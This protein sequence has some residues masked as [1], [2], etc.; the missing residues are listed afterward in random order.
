VQGQGYEPLGSRRR[1]VYVVF[2]ALIVLD[3]L[4]VGSSVL[5]LDLLDRVEAG[6]AVADAELE[7][8]DNRQAAVGMLQFAL[9]VACAVVFIRWLRAAY[10]NVDVVIPGLRR[11]GHGWAIG[12]WFVPFLNLWRPKQ[13]VNDTW[14]A[15]GN[16]DLSPLLTIWWAGWLIDNFLGQIAGRRGIDEDVTIEELRT[17]DVLYIVSDALDAVVA[18]IALVVV[19]RIS[20]RLDTRAADLPPPGQ[21]PLPAWSDDPNAATSTPQPAT[22]GGW[23]TSAPERPSSTE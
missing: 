5:E 1:A 22:V 16:H 13:I 17:T 12:A 7:N 23:S 14:R 3:L 21:P 20:E 8:N 2:G 18:V 10:R 4:A 9:L 6:E 15:G 19:K 11:Y